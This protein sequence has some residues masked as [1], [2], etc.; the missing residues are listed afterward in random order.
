MRRR[1]LPVGLYG[2]AALLALY[3]CAPFVAVFGQTGT[4][5]W[6]SVDVDALRSSIWI[7]VASAT[8]AALLIALGG[9]PLGYCLARSRSRLMA[10][11]GFVVQLPLALPPLTSGIL[12]LFLFGPFS[13]LGQWLSI[14]DTFCGIVL[15]E[16]FVAAPF[17]VVAAKSA[18]AAVDPAHEQLAATL[19]VTPGQRFFRVTLPL[20][21]PGIRA[22]LLLSWLRAF[23][24]FGATVMVA[25]HPYS[26]PIYTYVAF[27]SVGLPA[28]LPILLPTL[29]IALV[30][31]V[32]AAWRGA[33]P[34]PRLH[35]VRAAAPRRPAA[36]HAAPLALALRAQHGSFSLHLDWRPVSRRLAI[37]GASGSG[38]SLTLRLIAGIEP[39]QAGAVRLDNED[40][41]A[42]SPEARRIALV[43]QDYGLFPHLTVAQQ[44]CFSPHAE[45]AEAAFWLERLGLAGL[46]ARL[47]RA[48]SL[49]QQQRVAL[50]RALSC[51]ARALLLDEPFSALDTPRRR[52]LVRA[53]RALQDEIPCTTLL[54]T[55]D[56]DEASTL[57]DEIL[58]LDDGRVLQAGPTGQ[59]FTRPATLRVAELLGIDNVG[60][61]EIL[62]D[63]TLWLGGDWR[64]RPGGELPPGRVMWRIA[65]D[66]LR[67]TVQGRWPVRQVATLRRHGEA[68]QR[69]EVAGCEVLMRG[70]DVAPSASGLR[71]DLDPAALT[72]WPAL[73]E[74]AGD[75]AAD[76][77]PRDALV[78]PR[79]LSAPSAT[80]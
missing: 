46:E 17:L 77:R 18:F 8:V 19:G 45:A 5:D 73:P 24:E 63:G 37:L 38:K 52:A 2:L 61:G 56:P 29:V 12:L 31:A 43:P 76:Q 48:L 58:L 21:W 62:P 36:R 13:G 69:L 3:L 42:L 44:L 64:L 35:R 40:L 23:G 68:W 59:L 80:T 10:L 16:C 78:S 70:G 34:I 51:P 27:G 41:S 14:T 74:A 28:M 49:G 25:Y 22:G 11:L 32:L 4:A 65:P 33:L 50:A 79:A 39:N 9:I 15:A 1:R 60:E 26:L 54:V 47:P 55:H 20:A 66:G 7:S 57:A 67:L 53:L 75:V 30:V 71:L 6:Q 72:V